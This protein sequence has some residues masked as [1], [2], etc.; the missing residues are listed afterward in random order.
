MKRT[1]TNTT[2]YI[3]VSFRVTIPDLL[4]MCKR[5]CCTYAGGVSCPFSTLQRNQ[6]EPTTGGE[7]TH[8]LLEQAQRV[9]RA[10]QGRLTPAAV[11]TSA[12]RVSLW[13]NSLIREAAE[14]H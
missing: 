6:P 5:K 1:V 7:L 2:D 8:V 10:E 13:D 14:G 12:V 4:Q 11:Q 9:C 3:F